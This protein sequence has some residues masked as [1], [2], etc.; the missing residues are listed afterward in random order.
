MM[1]FLEP[2]CEGEEGNQGIYPARM[3]IASARKTHSHE[4]GH[5]LLSS[6]QSLDAISSAGQCMHHAMRGTHSIHDI[7]M[8]IRAHTAFF[9]A[10]K[11]KL[12]FLSLDEDDDDVRNDQ[13]EWLDF[14]VFMMHRQ[15]DVYLWSN[16]LTIVRQMRAGDRRGSGE[17]LSR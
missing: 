2:F 7:Q 17:S 1:P 4:E 10:E 14:D 8:E 15:I 5:Q 11:R 9:S 16:S 12:L 3:I 6:R 13:N